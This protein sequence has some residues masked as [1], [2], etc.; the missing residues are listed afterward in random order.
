MV[1]PDFL[2]KERW[3]HSTR[4]DLAVGVCEGL[5]Q[6]KQ[7]ILTVLAKKGQ[8]IILP[9]PVADTDRLPG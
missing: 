8:M 6:C 3:D 2:I 4:G 7:E 5:D 9:F 1:G